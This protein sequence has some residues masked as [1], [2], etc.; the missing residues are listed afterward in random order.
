MAV[1]R[2]RRRGPNYVIPQ[3]IGAMHY[4]DNYHQ[5]WDYNGIAESWW[6]AY[7]NSLLELDEQCWDETHPGPPF[8]EGGPLHIERQSIPYT[9]VASG[10]WKRPGWY[11]YRGDFYFAG[12]LNM[13]SELAGI[14]GESAA[15]FG[16][17]AWNRFRPT[18]PRASLGQFLGE[19]RDFP[20]ITA[21]KLKG[22]KRL[23]D[24]YLNI[25]FGWMPFVNDIR[26]AVELYRRI[27]R[28]IDYIRKNNGRWIRRRGTIRSDST[29]TSSPNVGN[30]ITPVLATW[31][32]PGGNTTNATFT[33][34]VSDNIW[35]EGMMKYYI[36]ELSRDRAD[37]VFTSPLLRR[38]YG[39]ELD[40]KLC[41]ELLPWSWLADWFAN[42][43]DV[44]SNISNQSYDNLVAKY[45]YV[46][47][48]RRVEWK[49][50]QHQPMNGG[51]S[52]DLN[53]TCFVENK[54]RAAA[55]PFGWGV[56]WPDFSPSQLA[57]LA[58]LGVTR[59]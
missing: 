29:S 32:Y 37:D 24:E 23:G 33:R 9:P 5:V 58:A 34:T 49:Y 38:L 22:F 59:L 31:F 45:A 4:W 36:P 7:A 48:S 57:I 41:W 56:E 6:P 44:I 25:K 17:T 53:V 21:S 18:K 40:P 42:T 16:A 47:R 2:Y 12:P 11:E 20:R 46:M 26:K 55:S 30:C 14:S 50:S 51:K 19:L 3:V 54:E 15:G 10:I 8:R 27:D 43:G 35:F 1:P 52:I 39:L 13:N 28:V